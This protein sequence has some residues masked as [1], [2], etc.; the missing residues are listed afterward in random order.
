MKKVH[1]DPLLLRAISHKMPIWIVHS[2]HVFQVFHSLKC[3]TMKYFL[4][5]YLKEN[6]SVILF[7]GSLLFHASEISQ[8][9]PWEEHVSFRDTYEV[10]LQNQNYLNAGIILSDL[11]FAPDLLFSNNCWIFVLE[12]FSNSSRIYLKI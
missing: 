9:P 6:L 3:P 10:S 11:Y 2:I 12:C 4:S 5:K 1:K 7:C 8:H